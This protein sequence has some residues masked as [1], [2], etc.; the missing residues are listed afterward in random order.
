MTQ[1][2]KLRQFMQSG[3][4]HAALRLAVSWPRLG[5]EKADIERAYNAKNHPNFYIEIGKNPEEL[6]RV[7]LEALRRKYNIEEGGETHG[8]Q[9]HVG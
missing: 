4:Y 3:E 9:D 2:D 6:I 1:L 8:F 7:G 5:A